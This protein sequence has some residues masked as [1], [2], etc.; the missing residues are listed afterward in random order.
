MAQSILQTWAAQVSVTANQAIV[1]R[2]GWDYFLQFPPPQLEADTPL[3]LRP[4]R[5]E[6]LVQVK[7]IGTPQKRIRVSLRN[8]EKL[9]K[10]H[11]PAFFLIIDFGDG[12][13]PQNAY[14]VHVGE[15]WISRVLR[16]LR[17]TP[18]NERD[19]LH[20]KYLYL[21][22]D[23][24]NCLETLNGPGL[25][26]AVRGHV[27]KDVD[28]YIRKKYEVLLNAGDPV[29]ARMHVTA[30]FRNVDE[31]WTELVD[32]AIGIRDEI[33]TSKVTIEEQ[34]R[35]GIP[36]K[37]IEHEEGTLRITERPAADVKLVFRNK[38]GSRKSV[39]PAKVYAPNY[40]FRN[41][42]LPEKYS[43]IR[44]LFEIG[45][46]L[47]SAQ[48]PNVAIDFQFRRAKEF[49]SLRAHF[50]LWQ[51]VYILRD[52]ENVGSVLEIQGSAGSHSFESSRI[53]KFDDELLEI[54]RAVDN[55]WFLA[56]HFDIPP[57]TEVTLGQICFQQHLIELLRTVC[58]VNRPIDS[59]EGHIL[60]DILESEKDFAVAFVRKLVL[61]PHCVFVSLG[62]TGSIEFGTKDNDQNVFRIEKPRRILVEHILKEADT[63]VE[64]DQVLEEL[65]EK[66]ESKGYDVIKFGD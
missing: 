11:L 55:A 10:S 28:E 37:C 64:S 9:V 36:T 52:L 40:L 66:L 46:I 8:W 48:T 59:I 13:D 65:S 51:V 58:D 4:P 56:R 6:C 19:L 24:T 63:D 57:E 21:T 16:R 23:E 45:E 62:L 47:I 29:I 34:I 39:F 17:E 27:G 43:K 30:T 42:Q 1:D 32:F 20:R 35:F 26:R 31:M 61:G 44:I 25:E 5:I 60:E 18:S 50:N 3:D 54:A 7:G 38:T 15:E 14:L 53:V 49:Q 33:A 2:E 41:K 12:I 22:W